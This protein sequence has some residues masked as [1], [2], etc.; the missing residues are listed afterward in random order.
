MGAVPSRETQRRGLYFPRAPAGNHLCGGRKH[1]IVLIPLTKEFFPSPD[2]A[3][4]VQF[5]KTRCEAGVNYYFRR[6]GNPGDLSRIPATH[7]GD[8]ESYPS[9][10]AL[11]CGVVERVEEMLFDT[12]EEMCRA[13]ER[14]GGMSSPGH[15]DVKKRVLPILCAVAFR[16]DPN[17]VA[18]QTGHTGNF[19]SQQLHSAMEQG[20]YLCGS[21]VNIVGCFG[22]VPMEVEG[23][24]VAAAGLGS[25][26]GG[27]Q[28]YPSRQTPP[29]PSLPDGS[30]VSGRRSRMLSPGAASSAMMAREPHE[31]SFGAVPVHYQRI[32]MHPA[33]ACG[34]S[35]ASSPSYDPRQPMLQQRPRVTVPGATGHIHLEGIAGSNYEHFVSLPPPVAAPLAAIVFLTKSA[36][37]Q[38][39]SRVTFLAASMYCDQLIDAGLLQRPAAQTTHSPYH[40]KPSMPPMDTFSFSSLMTNVPVL[41]FLHEMRCRLGQLG[42]ISH[43]YGSQESRSSSIN[44]STSNLFGNSFETPARSDVEMWITDDNMLHGR[45]GKELAE[46][47]C[48]ALAEHPEVILRRVDP[49]P[50]DVPYWRFRGI[51][52]RH[53]PPPLPLSEGGNTP[54]DKLDVYVMGAAVMD[55]FDEGDVLRFDFDRCVWV[56]DRSIPLDAVVLAA[57][58]PHCKAAREAPPDDPCWVTVLQECDDDEDDDDDGREECNNGHN[59]NNN[60]DGSNSN[61]NIS[62]ERV[63]EAKGKG[64]KRQK[65]VH[66]REGIFYIYRFELN[67]RKYYHGTVPDFAN[68]NKRNGQGGLFSLDTQ[69]RGSGTLKC[70]PS[71]SQQPNVR[72]DAQPSTRGKV[73][74]GERSSPGLSITSALF[75]LAPDS[76]NNETEEGG[77]SYLPTRVTSTAITTAKR[78]MGALFH[79][80]ANT[81]QAF[82]GANVAGSSTSFPRSPCSATSPGSSTPMVR[83]QPTLVQVGPNV[84]HGAAPME[85]LEKDKGFVK[86]FVHDTRYVWDWRKS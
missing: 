50:G 6:P 72:E 65:I 62:G 66:V 37:E 56:A 48:L 24:P 84:A 9:R 74:N 29:R 33:S 52:D 60:N 51:V 3:L 41:S 20:V 26:S 13:H 10:E 63:K 15:A 18:Q 40:L 32:A 59:S 73:G 21:I 39:L 76:A 38:N 34:S 28:T 19:N 82:G 42:L 54:I 79:Y 46:R 70:A 81:R 64:Q 69:K 4:F 53:H 22:F 78:W 8:G 27:S 45:I 7:N 23:V 5:H 30:L 80:A 31:D 75:S 43:S 2:C 16:Y 35:M 61:N 57:M 47:L 12:D 68:P 49:L 25:A 17:K 11:Y 86:R 58:R 44:S 14:M 55:G 83:R 36:G 85:E 1:E 67:G 71:P 77:V